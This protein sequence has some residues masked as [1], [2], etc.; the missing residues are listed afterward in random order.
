MKKQ[1]KTHSARQIKRKVNRSINV[2][3][4]R[5]NSAKNAIELIQ[6]LDEMEEL[7]NAEIFAWTKISVENET[8]GKDVDT[9]ILSECA[10]QISALST[11]ISRINEVRLDVLP[12]ALKLQDT[13]LKSRLMDKPL[14][15][16]KK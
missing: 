6:I 1:E 11:T 9:A 14:I 13:M 2:L 4:A 12:D 7:L 8:E 3:S 10:T 16:D 15:S 5:L